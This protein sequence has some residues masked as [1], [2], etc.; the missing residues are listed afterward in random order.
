MLRNIIFKIILT[1]ILFNFTKCTK[2]NGCTDILSLSYDPEAE[3]ENGTCE[4]GGDGG[5]LSAIVI[6]VA[7]T[8]THV[9]S[10]PGYLDTVYIKYNALDPPGKEASSYDKTFIGV[11]GVDSIHIN[12]LKKGRYFIYVTGIDSTLPNPR[13]VGQKS[14]DLTEET[15][16]KIIRVGLYQKCCNF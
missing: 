12:G 16:G 9:Y 4:Y 1:L 7:Y 6:P 11:V 8:G 13:L 3:K 5:Q 14:F 2:Y 10:K 15:S